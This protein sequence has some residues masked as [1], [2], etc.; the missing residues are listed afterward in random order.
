M[1]KHLKPKIT[2]HCT[3]RVQ[4][5]QVVLYNRL[6]DELYM[7]SKQSY[8]VFQ[9]CN[10]IYSVEDIEKFI[11]KSFNLEYGNASKHLSV[12]LENF[13]TRGLIEFIS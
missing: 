3:H 10:G 9:L 1:K 5:H 12:L 7:I 13:K 4:Q 8:F 11:S 2:C 6:T